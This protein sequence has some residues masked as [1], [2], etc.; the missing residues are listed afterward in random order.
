MDAQGKQPGEVTDGGLVAGVDALG[1]ARVVRLSGE[2]NTAQRDELDRAVRPLFD[3]PGTRVVLDCSALAFIGS[4]G[5]GTLVGLQKF[6]HQKGGTL[7]MANCRS[8]ISA[9]MRLTRLEQL[10]P[11]FATVDEAVAAS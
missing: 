6:S 4:A 9:L 5:L 11:M 10:I 7:R 1:A 8:T 2:L 3:A